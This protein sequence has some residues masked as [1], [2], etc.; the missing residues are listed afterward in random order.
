MAH[1]ELHGGCGRRS[2]QASNRGRHTWVRGTP[3]EVSESLLT[4]SLSAI[5]DSIT[6]TAGRACWID[7][8]ILIHPS[9]LRTSHLRQLVDCR[10]PVHLTALRHRVLVFLIVSTV[11]CTS[12]LLSRES[13]GRASI[14]ALGA[15]IGL[16]SPMAGFEK[17]Q[18]DS[19]LIVEEEGPTFLFESGG[20][21]RVA[22][23]STSTTK[24][25]R[26]PGELLTVGWHFSIGAASKA[27]WADAWR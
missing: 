6:A 10:L 15:H 3:A 26:L 23:V 16:P 5:R 22:Y 25:A 24:A 4:F 13:L 8:T 27:P 17:A 7:A 11:T 14:L 19:Y 1:L 21:R 18:D 9:G 2:S 20:H 12:S